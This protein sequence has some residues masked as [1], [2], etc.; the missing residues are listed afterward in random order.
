MMLR[1]PEP[2]FPLAGMHARDVQH[3]GRE[4]RYLAVHILSESLDPCYVFRRDVGLMKESVQIFQMFDALPFF[5]GYSLTLLT[6]MNAMPAAA[7][8]LVWKGS[9]AES[10]KVSH[11]L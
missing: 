5:A 7:E 4:I 3:Q 10:A 1:K 11:P 8:S 2:A 6:D 9:A